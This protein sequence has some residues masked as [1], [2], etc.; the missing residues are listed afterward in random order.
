MPPESSGQ[1]QGTCVAVR[2]RNAS[3]PVVT[4]F[5]ISV[6]GNYGGRVD[7][8]TLAAEHL[9]KLKSRYPVTVLKHDVMPADSA[10]EAAQLLQIEYPAGESTV[11]LKQ[12]Q[13]INAFPAVEDPDAVAVLQLVMTCPADVFDQAGPEF[14]QFVTS[15]SPH[16]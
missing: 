7:V 6:S 12:I 3:D 2:E 9:A 1:P 15:I 13:I 16:Q 14:S 11:T 4:N 8:A 10:T 5:V